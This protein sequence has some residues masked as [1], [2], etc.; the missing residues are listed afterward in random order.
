MVLCVTCEGPVHGWTVAT[1]LGPGGELGRIWQV[2][3]PVTYRSLDRLD[4]LG[5]ISPAGI[6]RAGKGTVRFSSGPPPPAN[7]RPAGG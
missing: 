6:Q 4:N 5:L 3:K 1:L 7:R 2:A